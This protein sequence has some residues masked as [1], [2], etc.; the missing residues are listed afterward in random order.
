MSDYLQLNPLLKSFLSKASPLS[1]FR[2]VDSTNDYLKRKV[3]DGAVCAPYAVVA[4]KQ[5]KGKGTK[6]R[7]W[8]DN[9]ESCLKFSMVVEHSGSTRELMTLSPL[10]AVN[11]AEE[12]SKINSKVKVKW[13]NDLMTSEGN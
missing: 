11:L 8:V 13:P 12:F 6:G 2:K 10:L 9:S 5:V 4:E 3:L 1:F 7:A